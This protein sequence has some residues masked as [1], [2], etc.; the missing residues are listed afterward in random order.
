MSYFTADRLL[1]IAVVITLISID[2][3]YRAWRQRAD[4]RIGTRLFTAYTAALLTGSSMAWVGFF[5]EWEG[6]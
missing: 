6:W 5:L 3:I 1:L 2:G 4:E